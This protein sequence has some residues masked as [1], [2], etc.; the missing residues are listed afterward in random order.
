M[1]LL[2]IALGV[3]IL[4]AIASIVVSGAIGRTLGFALLGIAGIFALGSAAVGL[5]TAPQRIAF[6]RFEAHAILRLD[7]TAGFFIGV[8]GAVAILVAIYALGPRSRD[9]RRT[10]RTASASACA[11]LFASFLACSADDVL[12]F[13]FAW[14]L[15]ALA[16]YWAIAYSGTDESAP[17]SAYFTI[18]VTHVAGACIVAALLFLAHAAGGFEVGAV[19]VAGHTLG[20]PA[21]GLVLVLL[22][23]G[24]GAKFGML[25]MQAWLP[26]GYSSAPSVVAALMAGGALNAGFYG[27]TRFIVGFPNPPAWFAIAV[28]CIGAVTAFFGIAWACA[29]RDVRRLAAFSSVENGGIILTALGVAIAGGILHNPMLV[30][31]GIATAFVLIAAHAV[32]KTTLFLATASIADACTT[33]SFERLGGLSRAMPVVTVAMLIAGMSL[34]ALPPLAGFVGEWLV[35][36]ALMQAFR[37]GNVAF[38]V[39]FALSGATI[40]V[41]AGV[42]VVAFT[43]LIGIGMLGAARSPEATRA[44]HAPKSS[45]R[46]ASLS[47]GSLAIV[48]VGVLAV[49]LLHAI[50][51]SID[52]IAGARASEAMIGTFPLIQ[53]TFAGFSSIAPSNLG[54]MLVGFTAF[55]WLVARCFRR[56]PG[57]STPAWTSGEPYRAWTQ[58]TGTGYANPT[59][60]ILDAGMRTTRDVETE[61]GSYS[62]DIRP[63][64][65][66]PFYRAFAAPFLK[67]AGLVRG[68]QSGVIAAY[69]SYILVFTIV[70]LALFPSIRHW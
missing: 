56:T 40:G 23:V 67:L 47:L 1:N 18:V 29:Q 34:A 43:K 10:G 32:A 51:P 65:D 58:Y 4:G 8:L 31:F 62:S 6:G 11:I 38:E 22:L 16:F 61:E 57:R 2:L 25:P 19:V 39:A 60:V 50:G 59:R 53:P 15:L 13:I 30:G 33:T 70:L 12:L 21:A 3:C 42:A 49:P 26:Y 36:E 54:V 45:W 68:T 48:G 37:T 66:L 17:Q 5:S 35:L 9:E 24:F 69:L 52:G 7:P 64:F 20:A 28:I 27:V 41:A 44:A 55:F 63:F 46:S 14:E